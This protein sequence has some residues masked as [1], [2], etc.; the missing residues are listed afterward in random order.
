MDT[1]L[2]LAL[3]TDEQELLRAYVTPDWIDRP[4]RDTRFS[5]SRIG[6]I[7]CEEA[8]FTVSVR[9][10]W[11]VVDGRESR[12]AVS[13]VIIELH[14]Q[15]TGA[16]FSKRYF[17]QSFLA[18]LARRLSSAAVSVRLLTPGDSYFYLLLARSEAAP[19]PQ[20]RDLPLSVQRRE[21]PPVHTRA[22]TGRIDFPVYVNDRVIRD[23]R[24]HAASDREREVGGF[25]LGILGQAAAAPELFLE[26]TR[27]V[28]AH[29]SAEDAIRPATVRRGTA[30][31][32]SGPR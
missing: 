21:P 31:G 17:Y 1:G 23:L 14:G 16:S 13:H 24:I 32:S 22:S 9:P 2:E 8:H 3:Y 12:P 28:P 29:Y 11:S 15:D 5:A 4:V 7:P 18:P 25:L 10:T 6:A 30:G 26:V 20:S 19:D 27:F